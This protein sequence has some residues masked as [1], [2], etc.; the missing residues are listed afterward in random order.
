MS[1]SIVVTFVVMT[2]MMIHQA[3]RIMTGI[4]VADTKRTFEATDM[5]SP[6]QSPFSKA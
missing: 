5:M 2:S 3:R 1:W 6:I 4:L